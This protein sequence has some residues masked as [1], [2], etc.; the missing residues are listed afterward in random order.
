MSASAQ[1]LSMAA[2]GSRLGCPV[3]CIGMSAGGITPVKVLFR[4]LSPQTGMAFV[5]IH[6]LHISETHLPKL[7]SS[8]TKMPVRL[9]RPRMMINANH[10]YVL[11]AGKEMTLTDGLFSIVPRSKTQGWSNVV[12]VF[13]NSLAK[14]RHLGIAVILS[15]LDADGAEALKAFQKHG[16]ITIVQDP[17]TA[18]REEMPQAA[19]TTGFVDYVLKPGTIAEELQKIARVVA[20]ARCSVAVVPGKFE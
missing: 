1:G 2:A 8:W 20:L 3:V 19:I 9:A 12:T 11:P 18:E 5:L 16:G 13:L 10:V 6:H 15:G 14:S 7:L 17:K 4:A